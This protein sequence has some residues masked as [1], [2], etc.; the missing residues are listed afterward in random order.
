MDKK[1]IVKYYEDL[2]QYNFLPYWSKF[3]DCQHGGILNCISNNGDK[4][5]AEDKFTWSQ[6]RWLWILGR[7]YELK[8]K[9]YFPDVFRE[10]LK[11]W[12]DE[13]WE[14]IVKN[15]IYDEGICCFV[16]TRDGQKKKDA[17]TGRYD[18]SIYADC[19]AL[20]GMAQYV[21]VLNDSDKYPAVEM[22]FKSIKK[23]IEENDFLTEPYPIP[24]G[25]VTHGIPMILINTIHEYVDMKQSLGME[26]E[27]E[28]AYGRSKVDFILREL[29][30]GKGHIL[31]YK[32]CG[33]DHPESVVERHIKP[34]HTLEDAWFWVEFLEEFGGLEEKL[35]LISKII[36]ETFALGW[37]NE[38]G[39][40]LCFVDFE[41]GKPKGKRNG[42]PLENLILETWDMKLWWSHSEL[43][44]LFLKMYEVTGDKDFLDYYEKSFT[45]AFTVFPNQKTGEWVQIRKRDG[46]PEEKVVALPV[47]DPFHIMRNFIKI[48][49]LYRGEH[50]VSD[51]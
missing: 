7:I 11:K 18:A 31:E 43:L 29:H 3:V 37:D 42:G 48:I 33:G 25:F 27:E 1:S 50:Y 51:I 45:Y 13:A 32:K 36:K 14:F 38:Y 44:Y 4:L 20:I 12:M 5:L 30:D 35:P 28:I 15:S 21:K 10:L 23:R 40:L 17:K 39:G 19:F 22:L 26:A 41:G 16:L 2:V 46:T 34:G 47:K 9:G 6:G 49:E 8:E 24:E